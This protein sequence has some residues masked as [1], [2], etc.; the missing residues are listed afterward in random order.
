MSR[1]KKKAG[2]LL[3]VFI[4]AIAV[5]FVLTQNILNREDERVYVSME[6][7]TLPVVHTETMG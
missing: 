3:C 1:L 5:Y 7:A 4:A 6:E 2:I